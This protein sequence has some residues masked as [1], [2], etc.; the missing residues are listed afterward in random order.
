MPMALA[1]SPS[2]DVSS[3][4]RGPSA[5]G[6]RSPRSRAARLAPLALLVPATAV[7]AVM[8]GY[9]LVR[10]VTVSFQ[11]FGRAQ[12]F[13]QPAPYVGLDN[14]KAI[15]QDSVFWDVLWRSLIFCAVNVVATM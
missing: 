6:S 3:E 2:T 8:I 7:M 15:L 4:P 13:G 12:V 11:E 1:T 5:P 14:Y 10:L 9:P